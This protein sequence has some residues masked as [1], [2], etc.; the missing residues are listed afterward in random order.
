VPT[1]TKAELTNILAHD[2][3]CT[4]MLAHQLVDAFFEA[5]QKAIL[6]GDR[7]EIRDFGSWVVKTANAR[8]QARN[9]RTGEVIVVPARRKVRFK[10]G[11]I[12]KEALGRPLEV[13]A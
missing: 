6:R 9:P 1:V 7:I 8:P 10:P 12:V 13:E 11:R 2:L 3:G 4:K 5:V